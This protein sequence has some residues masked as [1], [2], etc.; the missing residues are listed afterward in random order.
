MGGGGR[1]RNGTRNGTGTR[2]RTYTSPSFPLPPHSPPGFGSAAP[3]HP[4]KNGRGAFKKGLLSASVCLHLPPP[5]ANH[6]TLPAPGF[7][8]SSPFPR[9]RAPLE[10]LP[11]PLQPGPAWPGPVQPPGSQVRGTAGGASAT[12]GDSFWTVPQ[13]RRRG[14]RACCPQRGPEGRGARAAPRTGTPPPRG[15]A[16]SR[17]RPFPISGAPH[18]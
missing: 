15:T 12:G 16:R 5:T 2:T 1:T 17:P 4:C 6:R 3:H 11:A 7:F 13:R 10:P 9:A 18:E 14:G 8:R